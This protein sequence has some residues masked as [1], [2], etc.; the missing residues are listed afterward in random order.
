MK[1][2]KR[3]STLLGDRNTMKSIIALTVFLF[4]SASAYS[5]D[6]SNETPCTN[7]K[8]IIVLDI[9]T[10]KNGKLE[11]MNLVC[12]Q[13]MGL[14]KESQK[15]YSLFIEKFYLKDMKPSSTKRIELLPNHGS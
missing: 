7:S 4:V 3:H 1:I 9:S 15:A 6:K 5:E 10:D 11:K 14:F 13:P 8:S 2:Q 12:E